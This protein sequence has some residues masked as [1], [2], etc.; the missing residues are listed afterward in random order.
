M[1]VLDQNSTKRRILGFVKIYRLVFYFIEKSHWISQKR[2]T[3]YNT[4]FIFYEKK[5]IINKKILLHLMN[6]P[7]K[8]TFCGYII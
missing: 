6:N 8:P 2:K 4:I 3:D 7:I 1:D 5:V